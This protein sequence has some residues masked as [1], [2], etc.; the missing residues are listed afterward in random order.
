MN[1]HNND[2]AVHTYAQLIM[3]IM[4]SICGKIILFCSAKLEIDRKVR[5]FMKTTIITLTIFKMIDT[6]I[7]AFRNI[8]M[9]YD[10]EICSTTYCNDKSRNKR[11]AYIYVLCNNFDYY[12]KPTFIEFF[13]NIFYVGKGMHDRCFQHLKLAHDVMNNLGMDND[14]KNNMIVKNWRAG[15]GIFV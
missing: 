6:A 5:D 10:F 13:K 2:I 14:V 12:G 9:E 7:D 1:I 15:K 11:G 4:R 3:R 8:F